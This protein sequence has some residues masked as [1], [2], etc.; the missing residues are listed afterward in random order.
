MDWGVTINPDSRVRSG[1]FELSEF[2]EGEV[3]NILVSVLRG[4]D[5][6]ELPGGM[7]DLT[8]DIEKLMLDGFEGS[9]VILGRQDELFEPGHQIESQLSDE[10]IS[11]VGM[12]AGSG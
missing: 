1:V 9:P 7:N 8:C 3:P 11:P 2:I 6:K 5:Q 12:K 10:E 4:D